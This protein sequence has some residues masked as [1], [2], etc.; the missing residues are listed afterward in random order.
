MALIGSSRMASMHSAVPVP[1]NM[2]M[3]ES[4]TPTGGV[5]TLG[6]VVALCMV[7]QC[8]EYD[9]NNNKAVHIYRN[10]NITKIPANAFTG[11]TYLKVSWHPIR[12][13]DV[14][15]WKHFPRYW[16]FVR[17]INLSPVNSPHE[18]QWHRA[19][20]F[21]SIC[22]WINAWANNHEAGDLRCHRDQYEVNVIDSFKYSGLR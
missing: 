2:T 9:Y 12:H 11:A 4:A 14:I 17:G 16:P 18:G 10:Y 1:T 5:T 22:A 7:K 15:K 8:L 13:D 3:S 6:F 20:M 21:S 19:L